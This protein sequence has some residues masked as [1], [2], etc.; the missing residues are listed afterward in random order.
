MRA[1]SSPGPPFDGDQEYEPPPSRKFFTPRRVAATL[2][3]GVALAAFFV[4]AEAKPKSRT[5]ERSW[6]HPEFARFGIR[7]IAILPAVTYNGDDQASNAT[8]AVWLGEFSRVPYEWISAEKV[9]LKLRTASKQR[10]SLLNAINDQVQKS[11]RVDAKTATF[12]SHL[13]GT[14]GLL[15]VRID[16]WQ[17]MNSAS[18]RQTATIEL[19]A[20]L[21]DAQSTELWKV[22]GSAINEGPVVSS[23]NLFENSP[24]EA[25]SQPVGPKSSGGSSGGSS[26]RQWWERQRRRRQQRLSGRQRQQRGLGI[27]RREQRR[28]RVIEQRL[29]RQHGLDR[30]GSAHGSHLHRRAE[31]SLRRR[32]AVGLPRSA[33]DHLY[34]LDPAPAAA[35]RAQGERTGRHDEALGQRGTAVRPGVRLG[36][37]LS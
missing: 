8:A 21:V 18:S 15:C 10:D 34:R 32:S 9:H 29:D 16:K 33:H 14:D 25:P 30:G 28:H 12:L 26:G 23:Q 1:V 4:P 24:H 37:P 20:T 3:L 6:V 11:G 19:S 2:V 36:R 31:G 5:I 22:S 13:L 27:E 35:R 7:R 17:V